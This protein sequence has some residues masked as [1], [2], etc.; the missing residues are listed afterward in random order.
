MSGSPTSDDDPLETYIHLHCRSPQE[1]RMHVIHG[2]WIPDDAQEFTQRGA[3]YLWVETDTLTGKSRSRA[4]GVHPRHLAQT[5]LATFLMEKLA[6]REP[7][8][9]ALARTLS[10]SYFLL[11][12][13]AGKPA[14]CFELLR[15]VDE[16]EPME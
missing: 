2:T 8:P 3:F 10:T 4:D 9:G 11:P 16:A 14:P 1:Q 5:A 15:Y 6:L 13:A 7:V 12:T